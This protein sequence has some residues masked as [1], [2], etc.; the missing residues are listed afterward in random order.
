MRSYSKIS[1][2][3]AELTKFTSLPEDNFG[4]L[5]EDEKDARRLLWLV[6]QIGEAKLRKSAAKRGQYPDSQLLVSV[7]LQ[8]F[9][10]KV[11]THVYAEVKV[12]IY[13]AYVLALSDGSAV[14]V[15]MTGD[16]P[17]RAY[18]FVKTANYRENFDDALTALFDREK[19]MAFH[20]SSNSAARAIEKSIK[21]AFA[22]RRVESPYNRGLINYGCGGHKEWFEHSAYAEIVEHLARHG[23][24]VSLRASLTWM[25]LMQSLDSSTTRKH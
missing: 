6:N 4:V 23:P 5:V 22:A 16:W 18:S 2:P 9:Q 25:D 12:P 13:C 14:K 1:K 15:G 17:G 21:K 11:P 3:S 20:V 10:L 7:I 24:G 8:R 19:S